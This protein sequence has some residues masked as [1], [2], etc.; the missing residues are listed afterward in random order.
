MEWSEFQIK[1]NNNIND[2]NDNNDNKNIHN[3]NSNNDDD[4]DNN[5]NNNKRC[6]KQRNEKIRSNTIRGRSS[7]KGRQEQQGRYS[8]AAYTAAEFLQWTRKTATIKQQ[9]TPR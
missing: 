3:N 7:S 4:D 9:Q 5:N 8:A 6:S 2:N 1:N